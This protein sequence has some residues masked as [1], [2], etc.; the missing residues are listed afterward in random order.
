[1]NNLLR[2]EK[3]KQRGAVLISGLL[4]L[5]V[6]SL[7]GIASLNTTTVE[8]EATGNVKMNKM[9]FYAANSGI[10]VTPR[11]IRDT[12]HAYGNLPDKVVGI[13]PNDITVLQFDKDATDP[14]CFFN[15]LNGIVP[16]G[17]DST[18]TNPDIQMVM[19]DCT[20]AVDVFRIITGGA[21]GTGGGL[22]PGVVFG[23]GGGSN[24]SSVMF[25]QYNFNALGTAPDRSSAM[26]GAEYRYRLQ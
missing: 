15:E 12:L 25:I 26:V 3:K 17:E 20:V 10:E 4:I 21:A 1:M 19:G 14:D 13:P 5:A 18:T 24:G 9:A 6:L 23:R 22:Q 2:D 16:D 11:L 7:V 8:I